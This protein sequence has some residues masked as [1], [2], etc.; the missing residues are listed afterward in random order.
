[1]VLNLAYAALVAEG[2]RWLSLI[3][4]AIVAYWFVLVFAVSRGFRIRAARTERPADIQGL[5]AA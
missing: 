3:L 1:V 5:R 4:L 2:V